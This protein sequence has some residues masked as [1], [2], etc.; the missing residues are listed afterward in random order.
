MVSQNERENK[1]KKMIV[2][3]KPEMMKLH[4]TSKDEGTT[5]KISS[6]SLKTIFFLK[7]MRCQL[8]RSNC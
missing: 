8:F 7:K 6:Q 2:D 4:S 5:K 3:T 1:K